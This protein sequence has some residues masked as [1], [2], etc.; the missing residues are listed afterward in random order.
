MEIPFATPEQVEAR[1]RMLDPDE[2]ARCAQLLSDASVMIAE[3]MG[4][5]WE[6]I[7]PDSLTG[8]A[9]QIVACSMVIR[10]MKS[11]VD[12]PAATNYSQSAV[13]YSESFTYANPSGDLY[14]RDAEKRMLGITG[15]RIW[16]IR[17]AI[18]D[19]GGDEIAGW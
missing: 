16:A 12:M 8:Q 13:G 17:P 9:M 18:H 2:E 19:R 7:E 10:A 11:P 6:D 4:P 5:G 1:W 15:G 14:L 3:A